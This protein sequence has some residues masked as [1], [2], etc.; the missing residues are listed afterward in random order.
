VDRCLEFARD[1]GIRTISL[2]VRQSNLGAQEFYRTLHFAALYIRPQRT[3][4][5][6]MERIVDQSIPSEVVN[7]PN[8]DWNSVSNA[9]RPRGDKDAD[10]GHQICG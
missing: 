7:N 5:R 3:I 2:E 6:V 9:V 10:Q 4:V 1:N 8:V